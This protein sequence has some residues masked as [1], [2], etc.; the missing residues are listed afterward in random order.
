MLMVIKISGYDEDFEA[1]DYL[2]LKHLVNGLVH[3]L[4]MQY[5]VPRKALKKM[6][7]TG[8]LRGAWASKFDIQGFPNRYRLVFDY[9]PNARNPTSLRLI[10]V[11][12]RFGDQVYRTAVERYKSINL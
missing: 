1:L 9:L 11:G 3:E 5:S 8:D 6:Q 10:A 4:A 2:E 7:Q 12:L